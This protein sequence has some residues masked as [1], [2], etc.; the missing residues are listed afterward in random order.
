MKQDPTLKFQ[1]NTI[2]GTIQ[3]TNSLGSRNIINDKSYSNTEK[4]IKIKSR[5]GSAQNEQI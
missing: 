3:A 1:S 4:V 5:L 2:D